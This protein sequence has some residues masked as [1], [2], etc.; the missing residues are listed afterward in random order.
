MLMTGRSRPGDPKDATLAA[1]ATELLPMAIEVPPSAV[2]PLP[3]T[4][5][6]V[7]PAIA[8][9]PIAM[10]PLPDALAS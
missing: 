4:T 2:A 10:A 3:M 6:P 9:R 5:D 1:F 8:V 7:P